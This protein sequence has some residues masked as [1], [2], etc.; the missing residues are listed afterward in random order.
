MC[1]YVYYLADG[2]L[3]FDTIPKTEKLNNQIV[4]TRPK[5]PYKPP[6]RNHLVSNW[7]QFM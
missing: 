1:G 5:V 6:S 7:D 2:S 4:S 3:D